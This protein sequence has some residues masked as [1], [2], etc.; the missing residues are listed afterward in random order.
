MKK[1]LQDFVSIYAR[2]EQQGLADSYFKALKDNGI[3]SLDDVKNKTSE[4]LYEIFKVGIPQHGMML[5]QKLRNG[6]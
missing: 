3:A 4:E 1:Y 6:I 5:L 2:K